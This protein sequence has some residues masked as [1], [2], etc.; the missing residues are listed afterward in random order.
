[1]EN[2]GFWQIWRLAA[3]FPTIDVTQKKANQ[4][5]AFSTFT[6]LYYIQYDH[7]SVKYAVGK[8]LD[9]L[10]VSYPNLLDVFTFYSND[11]FL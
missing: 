1:M 5:Q 4:N 8:K 2:I 3:R 6:F 11:A 9:G 7:T 10:S